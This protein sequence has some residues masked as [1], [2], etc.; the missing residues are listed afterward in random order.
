MRLCESRSVMR[1]A[2]LA[3]LNQI[4]DMYMATREVATR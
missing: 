4:V 1:I 3:N 2:Q